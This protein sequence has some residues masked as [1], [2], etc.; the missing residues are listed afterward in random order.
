MRRWQAIVMGR[1]NC[2]GSDGKQVGD[3]TRSR[4]SRDHISDDL[5]QDSAV[6]DEP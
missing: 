3:V 5:N 2:Q 1:G 4:Y 6:W